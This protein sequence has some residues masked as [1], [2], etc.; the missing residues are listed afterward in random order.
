[1]KFDKPSLAILIGILSTIPY[2]IITRIF[3]HYGFAKYSVY[4]LTSLM[5][6]LN[7]PN[8]GLGIVSSIILGGAISLLLLFSLKFLRPNNLIIKSIGL[9][10]LSWLLLEVMFMWLIEGRELI[11]HR[12]VSDY[13]SE[14]IG[15]LIFGLTQGILFRKYLVTKTRRR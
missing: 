5:I 1:M 11:P 12:P 7:R 4:Q 6:T 2:E 3:L 8:T 14:M 9:T 13:Y 15:S 10:L